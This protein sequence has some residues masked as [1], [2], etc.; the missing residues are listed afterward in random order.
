MWAGSALVAAGAAAVVAMVVLPG[1]EPG[2]GRGVVPAVTVAPQ[3]DDVLPSV[4]STDWVTYADQVVV[5]RPTSD[6]EVP[7][8]EEENKAGEGYI[9]R[10]VTLAVDKVL[11]SRSGSP[12]VPQSLTLDAAGWVLRDGQR[13]E[14][15]VHGT[16][17]LETGHT[18]ILALARLGDG[19]WSILGSG[20]A[21][22][23]DGGVIGNGEFE[24]SI[25]E[26]PSKGPGDSVG[27]QLAGES[28]QALIALLRK[29]VPD[30]AAAPYADLPPEERPAKAGASN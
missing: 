4:T 29:T 7:A 14:F 16:P 30:P 12:A 24:G 27:E 3:A 18:Y 2:G 19:T 15:A 23:Y 1:D 26:A 8:T 5:A 6:R 28:A 17:R 11:W 9:G 20:A 13:Q 10:S 25:V 22:P 21:L